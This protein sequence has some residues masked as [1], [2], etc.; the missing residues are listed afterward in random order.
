MRRSPIL[1]LVIASTTLLGACSESATPQILRLQE[2]LPLPKQLREV[3]GIAWDGRQLLGIQDEIGKLFTLAATGLV[4]DA[5]R[6]GPNADYED[7]ALVDDRVFVLRSDGMLREFARARPRDLLTETRLARAGEVH[8]FESLAYDARRERLLF[9]HKVGPREQRA[10]DERRLIHAFD[11]RTRQVQEQPALTIRLL[12]VEARA[13]QLGVSL[14]VR[15]GAKGRG[16]G[17]LQL[18]ISALAMQPGAD[19]LWVLGATERVLLAVTMQGEVERVHVFDASELPQPEGM[20]LGAPD[21]LW[22]ASEGGEGAARLC[23]F[24]I[25][26]LR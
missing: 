10:A 9:A 17:D 1:V 5:E 20:C 13:R 19:R 26:P 4:A 16:R 22:I 14:P 24:E 15:S 2:S 8:E 25:A 6:F 11:L 3:S 12:D 18:R 7:L 21:Q 23:R